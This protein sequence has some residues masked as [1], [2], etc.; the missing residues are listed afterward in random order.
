VGANEDSSVQVEHGADGWTFT[1]GDEAVWQV[2]FDFAVSIVTEHLQVRIEKPFEE[3]SPEG[4]VPVEPGDPMNSSVV[5]ALHQAALISATVSTTGALLMS[6]D[7][8]R[9]LS[10]SPSD[11]PYE[12]FSLTVAGGWQ[13]VSMPGGGVI[14]WAPDGQDGTRSGS[15]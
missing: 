10:V 4:A 8:G 14:E 2:A 1:F 15:T 13:L 11:D 6:F 9:S 12:A 7:G 5:V 3:R